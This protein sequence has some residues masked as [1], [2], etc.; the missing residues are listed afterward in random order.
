[1]DSTLDETG[2]LRLDPQACL[3]PEIFSAV[4]QYLPFLTVVQLQRVSR[5]WYDAIRYSSALFRILDFSE[6]PTTVTIRIIAECVARS[7]SS[8]AEISLGELDAETETQAEEFILEQGKD[9]H[10]LTSLHLATKSVRIFSCPTGILN[11]MPLLSRLHSLTIHVTDSPLFMTTV[12]QYPLVT[13][14]KLHFYADWFELFRETVYYEIPAQ[15]RNTLPNI[16]TLHIGSLIPKEKYLYKYLTSPL[17]SSNKWILMWMNGLQRLLN[18]MPGIKTFRLVRI[19]A[20]AIGVGGFHNR[21]ELDF[22]HHAELETV[23]VW[24]S[25][26]PQI[27]LLA[28]AQ[29]LTS[30]NFVCSTELPRFVLPLPTGYLT[31]TVDDAINT[32]PHLRTLRLSDVAYPYLGNF[33]LLKILSITASIFLEELDL[34]SVCYHNRRIDFTREVT[35]S[36]I[37]ICNGIASE[38][39][40]ASGLANNVPHYRST[41]ADCIVTHCPGLRKLVLGNTISDESLEVFAGL[42]NL[43]TVEIACAPNVTRFG[44]FNL[45]RV[46]FDRYMTTYTE[47]F[48]PT[49][50]IVAQV[51]IISTPIKTLIIR[52]CENIYS[53]MLEP[54]TSK[55]NIKITV[56][57]TTSFKMNGIFKDMDLLT[58]YRWQTHGYDRITYLP[59]MRTRPVSTDRW[60]S[61]D[62]WI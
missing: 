13:L 52:D 47:N 34:S 11:S 55:F 23:D 36:T 2:P 54:V 61:N 59:E 17:Y 39:I 18:V 56:E 26:V 37:A 41:L 32:R 53:D 22:T 58:H 45:L 15:N 4:L 21:A 38:E 9:L 44:I 51:S 16:E 27:L 20:F 19:D 40:V 46:P 6:V 35:A 48:V 25:M 49:V 28:T 10:M 3:P 33:A 43:E 5:A 12:L 8:L 57:T 31:D 30:V 50:V 7:R 60:P 42:Q 1:M 24:Y 29:K 14:R 62:H